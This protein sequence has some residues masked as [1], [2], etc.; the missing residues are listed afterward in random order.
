M[1]IA[2]IIELQAAVARTACALRTGRDLRVLR[3]S[4][5]QAAVTRPGQSWRRRAAAHAEFH[6]LLADAAGRSRHCAS[7]RS[8]SGAIRDAIVAAGPSADSYISRSHRRLLIYLRAG[9]G[10]GAARE[11]DDYLARLDQMSRLPTATA[12]GGPAASTPELVVAAD[13]SAPAG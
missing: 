1:T 11:M 8:I 13:R 5:D 3:E 10:D 7:A 4:V 9:D 2:P 12:G 6:G